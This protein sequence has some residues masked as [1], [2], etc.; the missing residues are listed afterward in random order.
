MATDHD[1]CGGYQAGPC[2][3]VAR[4]TDAA[5]LRRVA[6]QAISGVPCV[7]GKSAQEQTRLNGTAAL[8]GLYLTC[9][10]AAIGGLP[11]GPPLRLS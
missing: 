9:A 4:D 11:R 2:S 1:D 5:Y 7:E 10:D 8:N 3:A 6:A